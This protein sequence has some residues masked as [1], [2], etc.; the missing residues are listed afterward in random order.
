M[1]GITGNRQ[2]LFQRLNASLTTPNFHRATTPPPSSSLQ[3]CRWPR[4]TVPAVISLSGP[5]PPRPSEKRLLTA[6]I[7][8]APKKL[9]YR[10]FGTLFFCVALQHAGAQGYVQQCCGT[11][12][13]RPMLLVGFDETTVVRGGPRRCCITQAP[14]T[15]HTGFVQQNILNQFPSSSASLERR[16]QERAYTHDDK[17]Q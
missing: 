7:R 11:T 8:S 1:L 5:A 14:H 15:A 16:G 10:I 9:R 3:A 6:E 2:R 4:A 13:P 17:G 12:H